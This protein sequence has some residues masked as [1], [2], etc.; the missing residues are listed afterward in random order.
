MPASGEKLHFGERLW[1]AHCLCKC[2]IVGQ[3]PQLLM[4]DAAL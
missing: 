1:P 2:P 4:S 3:I